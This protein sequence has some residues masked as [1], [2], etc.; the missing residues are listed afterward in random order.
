MSNSNKVILFN[1]EKYPNSTTEI[2]NTYLWHNEYIKT[3]N[4]TT[5]NYA[6]LKRAGINYIKDLIIEENI[7][8]LN[9][10]N[11]KCKSSLE[12]FNLKSV[13]KCIPQQWKQIKFQNFEY[14]EFSN[15]SKTKLKQI[16]SKTVYKNKIKSIHETPTSETFF[17][18]KLGVQPD[19][20]KY[21]YSVPFMSTLYTKLRSFQFKI[22][23]NIL[24]TNEKLFRVGITTTDKCNICKKEVETL[25]HLFVTCDHVKLLWKKIEENLLSP[26][27]VD[28]LTEVDILLGVKTTDKLNP[29]V[30]H[31]I[32]ETKYYIYMSSLS[33]QRPIYQQLKNRLKITESIEES[34]AHKK[35]KIEKHLYKWYHLINYALD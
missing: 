8:S 2:R 9:M 21:Y 29:I 31:I 5:L 19:E 15:H 12:R 24:F 35:G 13:I 4:N 27:G 10:V 20:F 26:F 30:N 3:P 16:T 34:I 6:L 28:V 14:S 7:L 33:E 11:L 22:C 1:A 32:L 18:Y 23:H 17:A 25:S